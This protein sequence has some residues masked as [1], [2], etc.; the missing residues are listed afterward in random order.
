MPNCFPLPQ[1]FGWL[2]ATTAAEMLDFRTWADPR[3]F[4]CSTTKGTRSRGFVSF[5]YEIA[6]LVVPLPSIS[7]LYKEMPVLRT[8]ANTFFCPQPII[9]FSQTSIN[10][11]FSAAGSDFCAACRAFSSSSFFSFFC[12]CSS[13]RC[14]R[15]SAALA[16]FPSADPASSLA[17]PRAAAAPVWNVFLP[18]RTEICPAAVAVVPVA[19]VAPEKPVSALATLIT[20][21]GGAAAA[22]AA[23]AAA[24]AAA[25][26]AAAASFLS[27]SRLRR[28]FRECSSCS[29][30]RRSSSWM[31]ASK[32]S[33]STIAKGGGEGRRRRSRYVLLAARVW[34]FCVCGEGRG[35]GGIKGSGGS[36]S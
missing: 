12:C 35:E 10:P 33:A 30:R 36:L 4:A 24:C 13:S 26:A 19:A 11:P 1:A 22:A 28:C 20:S 21:L 29:W 2:S 7:P 6:P 15:S 25:D 3:V 14:L 27:D 32:S 34:Y 5:A 18:L 31:A 23:C 16:G 17:P 8:T 9:F